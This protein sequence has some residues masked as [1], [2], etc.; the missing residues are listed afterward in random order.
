MS[1]ILP[2]GAYLSEEW[3]Q[4]RREAVTASEI[5]AVLGISP[6]ESPF[7]LY[8]NK[9]NDWRIYQS[10]EME[11]GHRLEEP[12]AAKLSD[13][14]EHEDDSWF[15]M[16][17]AGTWRHDGT[18]WA[19]ATPDRLIHWHGDAGRCL[20]T[21]PGEL[22]CSGSFDGW[23]PDGSDEIPAHYQTQVQWQMWVLGADRAH[24]ACLFHGSHFRRYVIQHDPDLL[25]RMVSAAAAFHGRLLRREPPPI[26][27]HGATT[28]T[29]KRLHERLTD[30]VVVLPDQVAQ[31]WRELVVV[32]KAAAE[33]K[34]ELENEIRDR[35]GTA[36]RA[37]DSN[38]DTV[39]S[40][41]VFDRAGYEVGPT[42]VDQLRSKR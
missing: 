35:M 9:I 11:W 39:V 29:L 22:K 38:G 3:H 14:L 37:V 1:E 31:R 33:Q 5:A 26:D 15:K 30:D 17:P 4:A 36:R 25:E 2:P 20:K 27:G 34:R 7:S 6:W 28:V 24:V 18:P 21:E 13:R 10:E 8:W 12:I 16:A 23:G 19:L 32:A 42:T 40:R 41:S